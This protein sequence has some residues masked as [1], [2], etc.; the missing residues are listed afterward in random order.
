MGFLGKMGVFGGVPLLPIRP[1]SLGAVSVLLAVVGERPV[2]T[3]SEG[4]IGETPL[5]MLANAWLLLNPADVVA[6]IVFGDGKVGANSLSN[7]DMLSTPMEEAEAPKEEDV[8]VTA[9]A[10]R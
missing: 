10:S 6:I 9:A 7:S 2:V 8:A 4:R 3:A 1:V 5:P